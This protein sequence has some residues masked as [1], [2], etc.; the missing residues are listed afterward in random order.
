[1]IYRKYSILNI[2]YVSILK[3]IY[4]YLN[5]YYDIRTKNYC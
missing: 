2:Q 3:F 4:L 1:M 5:F